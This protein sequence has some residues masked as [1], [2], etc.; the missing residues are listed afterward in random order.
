[1]GFLEYFWTGCMHN[2]VSFLNGLHAFK[3]FVLAAPFL[4]LPLRLF[5][6]KPDVEVMGIFFKIFLFP[7]E[8]KYAFLECYL[9]NSILNYVAWLRVR[10]GFAFSSESSLGGWSWLCCKNL[11]RHSVVDWFCFFPPLVCTTVV[12]IFSYYFAVAFPLSHLW[13]KCWVEVID[14]TPI[15]GCFLCL[16][17]NV[18]QYLLRWII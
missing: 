8:F 7:W 6:L 1:M 4:F 15:I 9:G 16:G 18:A 3:I 10:L 12:E 17:L 14:S 2:M 5:F 13:C 11:Y